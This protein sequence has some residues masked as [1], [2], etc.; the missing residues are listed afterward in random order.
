MKTDI[1][2]KKLS[3]NPWQVHNNYNYYTTNAAT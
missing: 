2:E 3:N 1:I